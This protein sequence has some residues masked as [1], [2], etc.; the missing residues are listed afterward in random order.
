MFAII[1]LFIIILVVLA[2][3]TGVTK[4]FL[5]KKE[6]LKDGEKNNEENSEEVFVNED[7]EINVK[8]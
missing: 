8:I 6:E 2:A 3:G 4:T 7:N 5:N 1:V